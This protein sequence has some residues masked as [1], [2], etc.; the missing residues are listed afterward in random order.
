SFRKKAKLMH[1][2]INKSENAMKSFIHVKQAYEILIDPVS[3]VKYDKLLELSLDEELLSKI[4]TDNNIH[5]KKYGK[6]RGYA[7][8]E[9]RQEYAAKSKKKGI[10]QFPIL[11]KVML[12]SFLGLAF[13]GLYLGITELLMSI[14]KGRGLRLFSLIWTIYFISLILLS[15]YKYRGNPFKTKKSY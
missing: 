13:Y 15:W 2:D 4:Q 3:R 6:S 1:P 10:I 12:A 14:E 9:K 7:S 8:K 11:E 5:Y